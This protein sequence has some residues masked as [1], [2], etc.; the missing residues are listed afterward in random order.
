M[1]SD[2]KLIYMFFFQ[3]NHQIKF[4]SYLP[5]L[6]ALAVDTKAHWAKLQEALY[7]YY[8]TFDNYLPKIIQKIQKVNLKAPFHD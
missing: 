8:D 5:C 6:F 3:F 2:L 1:Q 7:V 4:I